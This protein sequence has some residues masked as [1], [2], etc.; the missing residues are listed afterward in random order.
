[1]NL[2]PIQLITII[3]LDSLERELIE[4]LKACE[5]KGYTISEA[6]GAGESIQRNSEWE[7]KNIRIE[8]LVKDDVL[9][10]VYALL[11]KKYFPNYKMI[12]FS[13]PVNIFRK[14]KFN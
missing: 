2:N 7:G 14:E 1:M 13:Q 8:A 6:R 3:A 9:E 12:A 4:D 11:S 10:K 5:V